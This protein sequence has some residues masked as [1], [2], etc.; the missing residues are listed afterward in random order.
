MPA[1]SSYRKLLCV[2]CEKLCVPC[3]TIY[4]SCIAKDVMNRNGRKRIQSFPAF[5]LI[6]LVIWNTKNHN[7]HKE[8]P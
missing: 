5:L 7:G 2:L 3:D 6:Q 1:D 8:L 4:I